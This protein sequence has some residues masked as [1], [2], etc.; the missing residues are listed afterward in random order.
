MIEYYEPMEGDAIGW[1]G[2]WEAAASWLKNQK[3]I[4]YA[5]PYDNAILTPRPED[6]EIIEEWNRHDQNTAYR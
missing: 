2:D 4:E 1:F 5:Y 6:D 3:S